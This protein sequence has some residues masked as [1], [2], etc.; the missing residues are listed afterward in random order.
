VV[1][2]QTAAE[3][4]A[5]ALQAFEVAQRMLDRALADPNWTAAEE[6]TGSFSGLAP[7][8]IVDVDETVL[9]NSPFEARQ[10]RAGQSFSEEVW[11]NW[12]LEANAE[13]VPGALSF[14]RDVAARGITVFYV[15]N[16]M[17]AQEDSTR[18]NLAR[19]GFPLD[20]TVDTVLSRDEQPEWGS[21]KGSRR[22]LVASRYRIL[23]LVGDDLGD[24]TSSF[25][26][27]LS[28]RRE[29]VER[30]AKRWGSRW[31]MVPNPAYGSWE[32]TV[33]GT[34]PNLTEAEKLR[35][36]LNALRD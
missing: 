14:A 24:F 22:A 25:R 19:R 4:H 26:G 17:A 34:E 9:D 10:I 32:R 5:A 27:S 16:R 20:P 29:A 35:R 21:D 2:M 3:Y 36:K 7:A 12:V 8:V 15:S 18:A 33:V 28:E 1:W 13:P 6:Q 23:L 31:I 11:R 30:A